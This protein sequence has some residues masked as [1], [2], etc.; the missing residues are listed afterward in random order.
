MRQ[1][2]A[3]DGEKDRRTYMIK[4]TVGIHELADSS[5]N[6]MCI[7]VIYLDF[8]TRIFNYVLKFLISFE[9]YS[10][11]HKHREDWINTPRIAYKIQNI[12]SP[13]MQIRFQVRYG[14]FLDQWKYHFLETLGRLVFKFVR[15]LGDRIGRISCQGGRHVNFDGCSV[16][17]TIEQKS[18]CGHSLNIQHNLLPRKDSPTGINHQMLHRQGGPYKIW[19]PS[20][21]SIATQ[22]TKSYTKFLKGIHLFFHTASRDI[23]KSSVFSQGPV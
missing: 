5:K 13:A 15:Q 17:R 3:I 16:Y 10:F 2:D 8:E 23:S 14:K 6:F 21:N 12:L 20:R 7:W 11:P 1:D 9:C 19:G 18:I 22:N 4:L